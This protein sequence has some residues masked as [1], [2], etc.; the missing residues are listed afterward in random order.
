MRIN[1]R[2]L[3]LAPALLATAALT[4]QP[5]IAS[6]AR[7]GSKVQIPFEFEVAGQIY[8]A[9]VYKVHIGTLYNTVALEGDAH[10]FVWIVG[11]GDANPTDE[12]TILKFDVLGPRHLLRSVQYR[13]MSTSQLDKKELKESKEAIPAPEQ[14]SV[15]GE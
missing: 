6:A 2:S 3:V 15:V 4:L 12:R 7:T 5:S 11:P 14:S 10:T 8:P 13:A 1:L 9:G